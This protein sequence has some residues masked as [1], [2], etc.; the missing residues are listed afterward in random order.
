MGMQIHFRDASICDTLL[1]WFAD[2]LS[3]TLPPRPSVGGA[4]AETSLVAWREVVLARMAAPSAVRRAH[5][6]RV[7]G[8][9]AWHDA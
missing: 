9:A 8:V 4:D 6:A 5:A 3:L 2:Q 1:L 7:L